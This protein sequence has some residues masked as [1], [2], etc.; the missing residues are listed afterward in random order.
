[1]VSR[2]ILEGIF[3]DMVDERALEAELGE[4]GRRLAAAMPVTRN[5][6]KALDDKA[7]DLASPTPS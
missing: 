3:L 4:I 1:M 6:L 7:M 2:A 5:P